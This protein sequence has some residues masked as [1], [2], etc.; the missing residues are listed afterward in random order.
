MFVKQ[1]TY[2]KR[3]NEC[4][5]CELYKK[6]IHVCGVCKCFMPIKCFTE[7]DPTTLKKTVCP[8]PNGSKWDKL[9]NN[10]KS[11]NT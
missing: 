5:E 2:L 4:T 9:E 10:E 3:L 1:E 7:Y 11:G 6:R 8:H